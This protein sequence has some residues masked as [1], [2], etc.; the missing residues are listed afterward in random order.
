MLETADFDFV[1]HSTM[2]EN[3]FWKKNQIIKS[4]FEVPYTI[5]GQRLELSWKALNQKYYTFSLNSAPLL[6]SSNVLLQPLKIWFTLRKKFKSQKNAR[7]LFLGEVYIFYFKE[8]TP[9]TCSAMTIWL[10]SG[11]RPIFE[12]PLFGEVFVSVMLQ[13]VKNSKISLKQK[14]SSRS[15]R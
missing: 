3:I 14:I 7:S 1:T 5:S 15:M 9:G 11:R 13:N 6:I 8:M 10:M 12:W 4:Y 2:A